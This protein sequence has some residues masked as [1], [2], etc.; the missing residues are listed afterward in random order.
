MKF[1]PLT[2]TAA[3]GELSAQYAAGRGI[4][5]V[6][7]GDGYLFFKDKRKVYYIPYT[8]I[9][10]AFRRVQMVQTKMCCGKGNLEVENLVLWGENDREI[11]QLQLPGARAGKILLEELAQRAPHIQIGKKKENIAE[12]PV[13]NA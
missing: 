9:S 1:Y 12:N 6:T 4:G 8:G 2:V 5:A 10:R 11:A 13:D 3:D 7:L